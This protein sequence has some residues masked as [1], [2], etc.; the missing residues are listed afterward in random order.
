MTKKC[1]KNVKIIRKIENLNEY[2]IKIEF[3]V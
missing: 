2:N 1:L 3:K